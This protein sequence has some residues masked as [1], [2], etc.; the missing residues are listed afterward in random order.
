MYSYLGDTSLGLGAD[1][2]RPALS[3]SKGLTL[4][5]RVLREKDQS[6]V[7]GLR[8]AGYDRQASAP[9]LDW[10]GSWPQYEPHS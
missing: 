1:V 9:T 8:P 5:Q 3:L 10:L 2:R 7:T 4:S 6:L